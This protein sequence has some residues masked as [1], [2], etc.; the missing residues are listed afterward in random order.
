MSLL[1]G[2]TVVNVTNHH[3]DTIALVNT[4]YKWALKR[5]FSE[6]TGKFSLLDV[7]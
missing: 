6:K 1:I 4:K 5:D 3:Y 2:H 7:F